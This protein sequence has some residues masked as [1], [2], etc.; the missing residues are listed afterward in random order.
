[1]NYKNEQCILK[2]CKNFDIGN[3]N[4]KVQGLEHSDLA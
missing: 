4:S 1:M 2:I 3:Y